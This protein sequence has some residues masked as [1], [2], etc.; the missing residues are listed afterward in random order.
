MQRRAFTASSLQGASYLQR[1]FDKEL[2]Q[3][4]RD[5]DPI[6]GVSFTGLF[7]FF[8]TAF[9]PRWV[10]W[11]Q[12]D[13]SLSWG[14]RV[15]LPDNLKWLYE[16]GFLAHTEF[17][18]EGDYFWKVERAFEAYWKD[19]VYSTVW[20]YC[21]RH[22][23]RRPNRCTTVKPEGSG[24]NLTG[25]GSSGLHVPKGGCLIRRVTVSKN[26]PVGLA[27]INYGYN[28]VP[29]PDDKDE[30]GTLLNDPFDP[31][32]TT[33]LVE[34]PVKEKFVHLYPELSTVDLKSFSAL[35]QFDFYMNVQQCYVGH[36]GSVTLELRED[37]IEALGTRI[38][39]AIQNDEGYVS[40]ALLARFDAP[41][42]RLPFENITLEQYK[43]LHKEVIA[44]RK[45]NSF[46]ELFTK[47]LRAQESYVPLGPADKACEGFCDAP[48]N[49]DR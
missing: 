46:E 8:V 38:Y 30:N 25:V 17:A 12:A 22:G 32:C 19:I 20:D 33:W 40:A 10:Y 39:Q 16:K 23:L 13:R 4:S 34:I 1:G 28:V 2:Y 29:S 49:Q 47:H 5:I 48:I 11:W 43:K 21:D 42:P 27:A 18:S 9:G 6:I 24:T 36:N 44:R 45:S 31:R 15:N 35:A 14:E 37:E 26:D 7:T 41:F 3:F